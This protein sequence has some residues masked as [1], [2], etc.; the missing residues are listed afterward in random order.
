LKP[1]LKTREAFFMNYVVT[2]IRERIAYVILNRP[3]K[4]NALNSDFV[5]ELKNTIHGFKDTLDVRAIV[6]KSSGEVFCAGADLAYLKELQNY[7]YE[8]NLK[9]SR[10]LAGLFK[11]I[12][13]FPKPIISVVNGAALAGGCGLATVCDVCFA[14]PHSTFG[15]TESKIGFIP[16]IVMVFLRKKLGETFSKKLL[17]TGEVITAEKALE[18]SLITQII[19]AYDIEEYT[20]QFAVDLVSGSSSNSIKMI[21]QMYFSLEGMSMDES[22]DYACEMNAKARETED[23]KHGIQSFLNK[24]KITW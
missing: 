18:M 7:S 23:C 14:T 21:K 2:E 6:I 15:Y 4:R 3:D 20:H 11:L 24:K 22:I 19:E 16:A 10:N 5:N 13:S 9:D 8:E 17:F 12:Y 1:P